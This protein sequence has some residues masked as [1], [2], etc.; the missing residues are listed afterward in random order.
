MQQLAN[1]INYVNYIIANGYV[2]GGRDK[3]KALTRPDITKFQVL[4]E[5]GKTM[6]IPYNQIVQYLNQVAQ[7]LENND[8]H[9]YESLKALRSPSLDVLEF[10]L[11]LALEPADTPKPL[12]LDEIYFIA[13]YG[14]SLMDKLSAATIQVAVSDVNTDFKLMLSLDDR[15]ARAELM[16]LAQTGVR[17]SKAAYYAINHYL[18]TNNGWAVM[19]QSLVPVGPLA[20]IS[21]CNGT[22]LVSDNGPVTITCED[23]LEYL[24]I[25][26][27]C[28]DKYDYVKDG[29]QFVCTDFINYHNIGGDSVQLQIVEL[30]SMYGGLFTPNNRAITN[31]NYRLLVMFLSEHLEKPWM[32]T[33]VKRVNIGQLTKLYNEIH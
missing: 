1:Y 14:K 8:I 28:S 22:P 31:G 15:M 3:L 12:G 20:I 26:V 9:V 24:T 30:L 10:A 5:H 17:L 27:R 18:H 11:M 32:Q 13:K 33:F 25:D 16:M 21:L 29:H 19:M 4:L 6:A 7:C 23:I 2:E